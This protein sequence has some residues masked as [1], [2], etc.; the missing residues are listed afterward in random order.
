METQQNIAVR[1]N[2]RLALLAIWTA[3]AV[4]IILLGLQVFSLLD[5]SRRKVMAEAERDLSNLT[6][7][8]Q[9]HADRTL[10]SAEQVIRFV[11]AR[12]LEMGDKLDLAAMSAEGVIDTEI[13]NQVGIINAQGIYILANRPVTGRL[14]LSDRE[15][16]TVHVVDP[17][18]GLFVSKPVLGRATGKWSIQLTRRIDRSNGEFAGVVVISI[19]PGYFT[20]FYGELNLGAQGVVALYGMDGIARARLVGNTPEFGSNASNSTLFARM[21]KGD[22]SGVYSSASVVDGVERLYYYRSM[23]PYGLVLVAGLDTQDLLADSERARNALLWQAGLVS[24]LI[25]LLAT[26]LTRYLVKIDRAIAARVAAQQ[27]AQDRT[28]QLNAIFALSPDGFVSFDRQ[29]RVKYMNPAFLRMVGLDEQRLQGMDENDFS[30]WLD[31][32]C[33]SG[34]RFVGIRQLRMRKTSQQPE[35]RE[36]LEMSNNGKRVLLVDLRLSETPT[37][38]QILYFRDVTYETEVDEIKS[39]FLSAAAHE[40]RTPMASIFGFSELL[41]MQESDE[42]SQQEFVGIIYSQSKVMARIL[43]ELLDLARIEARRGRDF[44]YSRFCLQTLITSII[45]AMVL[46]VGRAAPVLSM[47][48]DPLYLQA[49]EGKLR[50][51]ILNVLTNAYKYSPGGGPVVLEVLP[52]PGAEGLAQVGIH[53]SDQGMGMTPEQSERVFERFYRADKSGNISGTG[54]GMSIVKEIIELHH[55]QITVQSQLGKGTRVSIYLPLNL[56]PNLALPGGLA[57]A[58]QNGAIPMTS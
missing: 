17:K 20:R 19:D 41:A 43:D 11:T 52:T 40:L 22:M 8:N 32:H 24:L 7:V 5:D 57:T 23:A 12:Y 29:R 46:P 15:H 13:F 21:A 31:N 14:D 1:D 38:S 58:D 28:E 44:Q 48:A 30:A 10:R 9:E 27:Q 53:V 49:D 34:T 37:V 45:Q 25:V 16:F 26:A 36:L 56:P 42:A 55:G 39:E 3:A 50:Q 2:Q 4:L 47:P 18:R 6:R 35:V 33:V 54:L 51:A